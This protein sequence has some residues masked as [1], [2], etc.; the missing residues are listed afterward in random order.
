MNTLVV[1]ASVALKWFVPE[2]HSDAA[3]RLLE[4]GLALCAPDLVLPELANTL[5]KK[6][7]R[8]EISGDD[9]SSILDAFTKLDVEII[10]SAHLVPPALMLASSLDRTVYDTL[11][12]TLAIARRGVL[13]TADRKFHLAV[14]ASEVA[15]YI[16][17]VDE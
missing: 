4:S 1:D 3:V 9:A 13:I 7:R 5:W 6:T 8:G 15:R 14:T 11:Y 2:V 16:R 12:L 17:W 10:P